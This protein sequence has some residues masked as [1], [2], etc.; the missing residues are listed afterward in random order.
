MRER[1]EKRDNE[2]IRVDRDEISKSLPPK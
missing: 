2:L 1:K